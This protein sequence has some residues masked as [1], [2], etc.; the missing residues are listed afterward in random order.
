MKRKI[1]VILAIV[2]LAMSAQAFA[3]KLVFTEFGVSYGKIF[4]PA[5]FA[6]NSIGI[7]DTA[8]FDAK[9]GV[10]FCKWAD[11]YLGGAFDYFAD[12]SNLQ[13]HYTFF[14]VFGGARVNIMPDWP[15]YPSLLIEYGRAISNRHLSLQS[16]YVIID[17]PWLADYYN[18]GVCVNWNVA[19]IALL[20]FS[21]ERPSISN[22][23]GNGGEIHI[24]KTGLAWKI[25]Y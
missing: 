7:Y 2:L 8:V 25:F 4:S 15:V 5:K 12:R 11:L 18:Y 23:S 13:Q 19:D 3:D 24:I 1:T 22:M 14:P 9:A 6:D 16:G 10:D 20:S 21:V 17:H